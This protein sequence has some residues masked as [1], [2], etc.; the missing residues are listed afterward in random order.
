[1]IGVT[2]GVVDDDDDSPVTQQVVMSLAELKVMQRM[3]GG[4]CWENYL[5]IRGMDI[6]GTPLNNEES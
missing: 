1:M 3:H 5:R 2:F 4:V 6:D